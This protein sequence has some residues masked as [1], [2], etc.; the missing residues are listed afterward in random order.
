MSRDVFFETL[1]FWMDL[2][3]CLLLFLGP[4]AMFFGACGVFVL[5][6]V[7]LDVRAVQAGQFEREMEFRMRGAAVLDGT[8]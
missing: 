3:A 8:Q 5:W 1:P 7:A 2:S 6:G 4:V